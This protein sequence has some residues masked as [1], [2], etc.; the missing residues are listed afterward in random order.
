MERSNSGADFH[1]RSFNI[2]FSSA[3]AV[4]HLNLREIWQIILF[5]PGIIY[6]LSILII[7]IFLAIIILFLNT[8]LNTFI[9]TFINTVIGEKVARCNPIIATAT[10]D[11]NF[12][13]H[14]GLRNKHKGLRNK[15]K[16]SITALHLIYFVV[17]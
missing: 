11:E 13:K 15:H 7:L 3:K 16:I 8:V 2:N 17:L 6:I 5:S 4:L 14:K 10:R 9:N 1:L 12:N